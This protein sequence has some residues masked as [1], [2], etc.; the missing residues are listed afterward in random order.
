MWE[1]LISYYFAGCLRNGICIIAYTQFELIRFLETKEAARR[2]AQEE[3]EAQEAAWGLKSRGNL[4][5]RCGGI[6]IPTPFQLST[7]KSNRRSTRAQSE[8]QKRE[9]EYTFRPQTLAAERQQ[10]LDEILTS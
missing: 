2:K 9:S 3:R 1:Y 10:M 8:A 5:K 6:T 4:E 7:A